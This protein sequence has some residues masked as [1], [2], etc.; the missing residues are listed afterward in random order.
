MGVELRAPRA[1][2]TIRARVGSFGAREAAATLNEHG[3]VGWGRTS[4]S[5]QESGMLNVRP[6][7]DGRAFLNVAWHG[8]S[9]LDVV[10]LFDQLAV[11][12]RHYVP[13]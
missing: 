9:C 3:R 4:S 6:A 11:A 10:V 13:A 2:G 1:Y 7:S 8:S 5:I 12:E